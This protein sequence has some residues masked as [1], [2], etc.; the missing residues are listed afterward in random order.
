MFDTQAIKENFGRSARQYDENAQLQRVVRQHA[1]KLA[2]QYWPEKGTILDAGC[3]TG[4]LA[5]ELSGHQLYGFDLS[6]GMCAVARD[7]IARCVNADARYV[8]F[9]DGSFNGVFSSLMLQW[10]DDVQGA[11][12]EMHRVLKSDGVAV[13]T[14]LL[15]GT[16]KELSTAFAAI[17]DQPHV[18][19]FREL[20]EVLDEVKRAGFVLAVAKQDKIMEYYPDTIALMRSLQLIGATNKH[21]ARGKGL[22]TP[23]KFTKI[24]NAYAQFATPQGLPVTW[25]V[26]TLVLRKSEI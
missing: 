21:H 24:E 6:G 5:S 16:L 15:S 23:A 13:V 1:L 9:V 12:A 18:S 19:K 8:P 17:D 2:L 22:M 11:F 4:A 26:L 20:H 25:Q 3:G 10:V 14:T 7:V